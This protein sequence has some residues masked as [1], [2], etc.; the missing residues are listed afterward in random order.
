M[1]TRFG[2]YSALFSLLLAV[3]VAGFLLSTRLPGLGG[4]S[5]PTKT[6][7]VAIPRQHRN[8]SDY[9][10]RINDQ[11]V[12]FSANG[13]RVAYV[14]GSIGHMFVMDGDAPGPTY[15]EVNFPVLSPDGKRLAYTARREKKWFSVV[16]GKEGKSYDQVAEIV[17]SP[18]GQRLAYTVQRNNK[19]LVVVDDTEE[20]KLWDEVSYLAFTADSKEIVYG[21]RL[22]TTDKIILGSQ[23][24]L[25]RMCTIPNGCIGQMAISTDQKRPTYELISG[26]GRQ[27]INT[28][29]I[30]TKEEKMGTQYQAVISPMFTAQGMV[31]YL[32][33]DDI[34][35]ESDL[36]LGNERLD[37]PWGGYDFV[38]SPHG[39][40]IAYLANIGCSDFCPPKFVV[41][42]FDAHTKAVQKLR[43]SERSQPRFITDGVVAYGILDNNEFYWVEQSLLVG[44]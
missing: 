7:L 38:V 33:K 27:S 21:A 44:K 39:K 1:K 32:A 30:T 4:A 26:K 29:N 43:A 15:D 42:V 36:I 9:D 25:S 34:R 28:V 10:T 6:K 40:R 20:S 12:V 22:G 13:Q 19:W 8:R 18:G 35:N 2:K 3:A 37:L 17:F 31:A 5:E 23:E 41:V 16:D 24:I 11:S 14:V